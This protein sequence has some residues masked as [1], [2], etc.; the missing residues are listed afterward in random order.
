MTVQVNYTNKDKSSDLGVI[1]LFADEKFQVKNINDFFSEN[2]TSYSNNDSAIDKVVFKLMIHPV[3]HSLLKI[4]AYV[5]Q[6]RISP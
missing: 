4:P 2:E 5:A 3:R 6:N 1:V